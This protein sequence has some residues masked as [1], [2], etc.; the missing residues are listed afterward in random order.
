MFTSLRCAFAFL[1]L[2]SFLVKKNNF[3]VKNESYSDNE[4]V[5]YLE[6]R[7]VSTYPGPAFDVEVP[8][9]NGLP[10]LIVRANLKT[11]LIKKKVLIIKGDFVLV[12]INIED[13]A[14]EV[15]TIKGTLVKRLDKFNSTEQGAEASANTHKSQSAR[16]YNQKSNNQKNKSYKKK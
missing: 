10:P 8:R 13:M 15:D 1:F 3:K 2:A 6:G 5:L 7:V 16:N 12:E 9:K 14:G 4:N 11:Q